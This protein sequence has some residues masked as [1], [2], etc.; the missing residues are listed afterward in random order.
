MLSP[1]TVAVGGGLYASAGAD[2]SA[3]VFASCSV[4]GNTVDGDGAMMMFVLC[5]CCFH[6]F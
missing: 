2:D 3:V 1:R 4:S 5:I 6:M